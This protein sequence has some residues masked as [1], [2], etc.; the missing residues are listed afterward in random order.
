[1]RENRN[2]AVM[3]M[4]MFLILSVLLGI[5]AFKDVMALKNSPDVAELTEKDFEPRKMVHGKTRMVIDYYCYETRD[6]KETFRWYLV[7]TTEDNTTKYIGIKVNAAMF[8]SY[9]AM[10]DST[11]NFIE[12][13][14]E[15]LT[16]EITYQGRL[17][18][19]EGEIKKNLEKFIKASGTNSE[20]LMDAMILYYVELKTTKSAMI[21][22]IIAGIFLALALILFF[23]GVMRAKKPSKQEAALMAQ[24]AA[25]PWGNGISLS[26]D[27]REIEQISMSG[28][29]GSSFEQ[30]APQAENTADGEAAASDEAL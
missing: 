22:L 11:W 12:G 4:I 29:V 19:V 30:D 2:K 6:D 25:T 21:Q 14:S 16:K 20:E 1:M 28:G 26:L 3:G 9:K 10:Y 23:F 15:A 13:K 17:I 18:K 27:D 7:P 8:P 5:P 24:R